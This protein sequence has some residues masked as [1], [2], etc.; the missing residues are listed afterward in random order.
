MLAIVRF[1]VFAIAFA[2][3]ALARQSPPTA[4]SSQDIRSIDSQAALNEILTSNSTVAV[5][6][7]ANWCGP[8]RMLAPILE[9]E[10][11][12][13][14][15]I[16]FVKVNVDEAP[17]LSANYAITQL[18]TTLL[19]QNGKVVNRFSGV[20][21]REQIGQFFKSAKSAKVN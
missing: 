5:K 21:P 11:R 20:L 16:S 15:D 14:P 17:Q 2:S 19:F 13:N 6:F 9:Q 12:S 18:P 8:C 1:L 3:A 7:Y 4:K 10:A